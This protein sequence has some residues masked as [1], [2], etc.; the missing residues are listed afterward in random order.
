LKHTVLFGVSF[1]VD[2][3]D[4]DCVALFV[5]SRRSFRRG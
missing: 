3:D 2:E 4:C 5:E 1:V